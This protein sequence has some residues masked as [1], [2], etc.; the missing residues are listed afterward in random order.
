MRSPISIPKRRP[1]TVATFV[2]IVGI[3][4]AVMGS[5]SG[6]G[7]LRVLGLVVMGSAIALHWPRSPK[8]R[9]VP[10]GRSRSPQRLLPA[11]TSRPALPL[12]ID[13]AKQS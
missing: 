2:L 10:S 1:D 8:P 12:S 13:T 9:R 6:H 3:V 11:K 7:S 4:D 5:V